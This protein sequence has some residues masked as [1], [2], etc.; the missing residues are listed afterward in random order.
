MND[1]FWL[2]KLP[3]NKVVA[4]PSISDYETV[5]RSWRERL[6]TRPWRPFIKTKVIFSPIAYVMPGGTVMVSVRT[7]FIIMNPKDFRTQ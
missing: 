5:P 2:T 3:E 6:F 4:D 1:L 7:K